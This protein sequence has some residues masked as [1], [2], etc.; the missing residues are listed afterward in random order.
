M[1]ARA[2]LTRQLVRLHAPRHRRPARLPRQLP[3]TLIEAEYRRRLEQVVDRARLALEPLLAAVPALIDAARAERHDAEVV[4][5][6]GVIDVLYIHNA[7]I[8]AARTR[9]AERQ[10]AGE[11]DRARELAEEARRILNESLDRRD[12][13]ALAREFAQKTQT[14]QRIQ[15]GKQVKAALGVDLVS[16]R[17]IA[18]LIDSFVSENATLIRGL[19][20]QTIDRVEATVTRAIASGTLNTDLAKQLSADFGYSKN[21]A[22]VIARDQIGKVYGQTNRARQ[23]ELGLERYAWRTANDRRVR[24]KPGG[25]YPNAE[26]SHWHREGKIYKW[27]EP[28]DGDPGEPIQCRCHAEPVFDDVLK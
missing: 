5:E 22:R 21:R 17:H 4:R 2:Q 1:N 16:D 9:H 7:D 25:A 27:G 13:E 3:P 6:F 26:P 20:T 11:G 24:G 18:P 8:Q 28:D 15:L 23:R 12:I 14:W 10:D 19:G